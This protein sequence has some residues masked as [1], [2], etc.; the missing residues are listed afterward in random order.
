M[1]NHNSGPRRR[2][3]VIQAMHGVTRRDRLNVAEP[4]A[5]NGPVRRPRELSARARH[6]W[7]TIAP[8]CIEMGTLTAAD[9]PAFARLCELQATAEAASAQKSAPGFA[10]FL[11]TT[12]V[13]SAGNE[14]QRVQVHPAIRLESE[15]SAKLRPYYDFFGL[16]PTGRPR[17][18]VTK[19]DA[20][21]KWAG[22]L[23]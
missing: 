13:D 21:S 17:V 1:G 7:K 11:Y 4:H 16:T 23:K 14:H 10:L 12:T 22:L 20:P 8:L 3:N 9:V 15:T 6:V 2:A 5:P 18:Q 19:K